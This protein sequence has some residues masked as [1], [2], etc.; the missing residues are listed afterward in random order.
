MCDNNL[1]G[2]EK[3]ACFNRELKEEMHLLSW[4]CA[5]FVKIEI[6]PLAVVWQT[7]PAY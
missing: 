5:L 1:R 2:K 4:E 3:V 6:T 7:V